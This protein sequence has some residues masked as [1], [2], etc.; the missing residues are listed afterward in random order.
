MQGEPTASQ[1][2]PTTLKPKSD[3][4]HVAYN[5]PVLDLKYFR[6]SYQ[7]SVNKVISN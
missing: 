2:N 4:I 5:R 3:N 1:T 7:Q 6:Q